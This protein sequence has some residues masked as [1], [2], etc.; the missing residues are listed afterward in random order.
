MALKHFAFRAGKLFAEWS[1]S[2]RA[3]GKGLWGFERDR[4]WS[5]AAVLCLIVFVGVV[6]FRLRDMPLERDEGELVRPPGSCCCGGKAAKIDGTKLA[7]TPLFFRA[8]DFLSAI[9]GRPPADPFGEGVRE[10]KR[11]VITDIVGNGFYG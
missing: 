8:N 7:R 9:F 4:L 10:D 2:V 3:A 5:W 1:M 6:R 11:I